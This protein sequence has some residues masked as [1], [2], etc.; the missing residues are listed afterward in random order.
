MSDREEPTVRKKE[1]GQTRHGVKEMMC[2]QPNGQNEQESV[3]KGSSYC[4][5]TNTKS[6]TKGAVIALKPV[7]GEKGCRGT[8]RFEEG[9]ATTS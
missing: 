2:F 9:N 4:V 1:R 6:V 3:T 7:A 8:V 5:I